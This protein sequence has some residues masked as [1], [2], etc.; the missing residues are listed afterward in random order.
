MSSFARSHERRLPSGLTLLSTSR[1]SFGSLSVIILLT[2]ALRAAAK[3]PGPAADRCLGTQRRLNLGGESD[4]P[5]L[6][7]CSP[8]H[9]QHNRVGVGT[10]VSFSFQ[11]TATIMLG[12]AFGLAISLVYIV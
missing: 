9:R 12:L 5:D 1:V 2:A 3:L 7:R 11:T 8:S 6:S 4:N 10:A